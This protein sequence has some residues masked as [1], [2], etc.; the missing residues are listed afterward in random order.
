MGERWT[1]TL[2]VVRPAAS[3]RGR[4]HHGDIPNEARDINGLMFFNV[5][6]ENVKNTAVLD[7]EL[8][9]PRLLQEHCPLLL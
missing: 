3:Q 2:Y 8:Y 4:Q 7:L 5:S 1:D 6:V 9:F